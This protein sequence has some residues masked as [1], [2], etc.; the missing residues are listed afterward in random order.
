[1]EQS[2]QIKDTYNLFQVKPAI[3]DGTKIIPILNSGP[4]IVFNNV[5]FIYPEA[6]KKVLKTINLTI[7]P[8]E[9]IAI[10]GHN[11]A[12]KTTLVKLLCRI[13]R[14]TKGSININ[15]DNINQLKTASLYKNISALFQDYNMYQ[16]LTVE[17]NITIGDSTKL[18]EEEKIIQAVKSADAWDFIEEFPQKMNQ[19][20]DIR[21][22]GGIRPSTGQWQKLALARLFYRN[23]P[24]VIFDEPTAAID[25]ESEYK[26]FNE[27]YNFFENKT[28]IIISHRFS[29]VR[30]ADRIIVLD[31]GEIIEEGSHHDLIEKGGYYAKSFKLQ[32]EGYSS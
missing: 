24:L 23:A 17:E 11:G 20:L 4:K 8:N 21:Y 2:L 10:V 3:A 32:A 14:V 26:I 15:G 6:S 5:S 29:T 1:L 7:Q 27:I 31:H 16:Q 13:Y 28:V 22:K 12:G 18:L 30:N 25:A 19:I 9:K